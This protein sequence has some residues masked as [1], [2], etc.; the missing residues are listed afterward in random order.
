MKGNYGFIWGL[1]RKEKK[2]LIDKNKMN[3]VISGP[4]VMQIE[5]CHAKD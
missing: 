3:D 2:K 5:Y 1:K 4:L